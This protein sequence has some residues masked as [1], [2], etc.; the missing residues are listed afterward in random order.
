VRT[1]RHL[2]VAQVLSLVGSGLATVALALLAYDLAGNDAG[3]VLGTA[4]AIKM[5]AYVTIA[6]VAGAF[7]H[8][9]SR[10]GFLISLDI[11]RA[12]I[13]LALPFVDQVWQVYVLV[14]LLQSGSAAFT[15]VFRATIPDVL[16]DESLYTKGLSLSRIAYDLEM[17][18]SPSIAAALLTAISFHWLFTGT[19]FGFLA[20]A[21]LVLSTAIPT[22]STPE[23][24]G[25]IRA[26]VSYGL[27]LFVK[28]PRLRGL[29]ALH[30]AVAAAGAMV[31]VNT[32]VLVRSTVG[33]DET[34]V[35][36]LMAATGSGSIIVSVMLP[37]MLKK[38][39]DRAVMIAGSALLVVC[40]A[41]GATTAIYAVVAVIWV[42]IGVA[43][44]MVQTPSD[45]LL[46]RSC[47]AAD[48]PA[49]YAAQFALTHAC[50]LITYPAAGWIGARYG[51][52]IAFSVLC[53]FALASVLIA[54]TQWPRSDPL[55]LEHKHDVVDHEHSHVH[56]EHHQHEHE[57][58]EGPEPH[59]HGHVHHAIRHCHEFVIDQHH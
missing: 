59:R 49:V 23:R 13:V 22:V 56:G 2:F 30:A 15:P 46:Q 9:F 50:W 47:H 11:G 54:V 16:T 1:Y 5:I 53:V 4:L 25:G 7:A 26:R 39:S 17:L 35:A 21:L 37:S 31:I 29:L 43:A 44:S 20:S 40:L 42:L 10:R 3:I 33:G 6:P 36:L 14:F 34:D 24:L 52:D 51:L 19:A 55:D 58:W 18:L 41:A 27:R 12:G 48:R 32:V 28:T 38:W 45:R 8:R 57:G